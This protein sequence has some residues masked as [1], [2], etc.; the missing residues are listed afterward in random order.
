[1]RIRNVLEGFVGVGCR[2]DKPVVVIAVTDDDLVDQV[3][4]QPAPLPGDCDEDDFVSNAALYKW[5]QG[6]RI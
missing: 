2:Y 4:E 1:M 6:G 3:F 5:L